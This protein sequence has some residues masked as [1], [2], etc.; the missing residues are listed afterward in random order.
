MTLSCATFPLTYYYEVPPPPKPQPIQLIKP[1]I[2]SHYS[3][4]SHENVITKKKYPPSHK[5]VTYVD[6][7][8]MSKGVTLWVNSLEMVLLN[9]FTGMQQWYQ[10]Y[11]QHLPHLWGRVKWR[12]VLKLNNSESSKWESNPYFPSWIGIICTVQLGSKDCCSGVI[13]NLFFLTC[14]VYFRICWQWMKNWRKQERL[15]MLKVMEKWFEDIWNCGFKD[16]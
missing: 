2:Y 6:P 12:S 3:Q 1:N 11:D 4:P 16:L 10:C 9:E 5:W 7:Q 13:N 8:F 15:S 14:H